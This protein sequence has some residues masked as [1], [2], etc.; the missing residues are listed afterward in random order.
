[1]GLELRGSCEDAFAHLYLVGLA[2]I[3]EDADPSRRRICQIRWKDQEHAVL[4]SSDDVSWRQCAEIVHEHAL[5]WSES[6]W[7]HAGGEYWESPKEDGAKS[8]KKVSPVR[9][10]LSPRLGKP[11]TRGSWQKLERDRHRAIDQLETPLDYEYI[12]ALGEPSYW[13]GDMGKDKNYTPDRGASRWEMVARNRG[14]EFVSGRLL[15]LAQAV[16]RRDVDAVLNGLKGESVVDEVGK[17]SQQS[18]TPTG[19]RRPSKTD[20]AQ[21][22]CALF[23]VSAF[24]QSKS[25]TKDRGATAGFFRIRG[26]G[27][28]V[29][30]PIFEQFWTLQKYRSVV[31]SLWLEQAAVGKVDADDETNSGSG[32]GSF[33]GNQWLKEQGVVLCALFPQYVSGNASAPER[34][35]Q[36][37]ELFDVSGDGR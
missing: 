23:G 4:E 5:R 31:R 35:L 2:S 3:L 16:A 26:H 36:K 6:D 37:G 17:D 34:W 15:P 14:Q 18:R 19:L 10:T 21:A 33:A 13:S 11:N 9:A 8:K 27:Q 22:W 7:L 30:L 1:M 20:N 25:T 32:F 28:Y 29:V 24:P 12:G